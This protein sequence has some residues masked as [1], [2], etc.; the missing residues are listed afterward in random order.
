M[1]TLRPVEVSEYYISRVASGMRKYFWDNIF[2]RIFEILKDNT[3]HNSKDDVINAIKS[4]QIW[5]ENGAFRTKNRF[6]NKVSSTLE[7]L[8]AK[9]KYGAYYI[10]LSSFSFEYTQVIAFVKAQNLAKAN[11][12]AEYLGGLGLILPQLELKDYIQPA[13]EGMYK[14]LQLELIKAAQEKN[15]PVIELGIVQPKIQLPKVK[16]KK[17]DAYWKEYDKKAEKLQQDI[18]KSEK[19]GEDTQK[20]KEDL[21]DLQK[22]AF[23]KAP[24]LDIEINDIELDAQSK[25]IA[26]DYT[27]NMQYWVKKWETKNIIK[28]R[29][30]V[31]KMIQEG[32]RIPRLTEYFENRWHIA[33]SKA[34]FLAINESHLAASVIKATQYQ[35]M[36]CNSFKWGRSSS[37]EKRPLHETYYGKVFS[38]DNPP[39]IDEELGIKGL[40]RQIWN[41]KCHMLVVVPTLSELIEKRNKIKNAKRNIFERIKNSKQCDNNAWRY[42]RFG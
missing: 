2:K 7:K 38:F 31:L 26:Q 28:M 40:P 1:E 36:G 6:P 25:K 37:K 19:K 33:T 34:N 12:L 5:Y 8:G 23:E 18:L 22:D 42:R 13:V 21:K 32:A 16:T 30:E 4:G 9:Y 29:Q 14:N 10:D 35:M 24:Q 3:I 20:L 11:S 39:V 17:I 15:V 41:C 27:Y